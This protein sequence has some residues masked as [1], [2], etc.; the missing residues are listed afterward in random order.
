MQRAQMGSGGGI[1][2]QEGGEIDGMM[3]AREKGERGNL[4]RKVSPLN[5]S[6]QTRRNPP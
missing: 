2:R 3:N 4:F 5:T 6:S 1:F